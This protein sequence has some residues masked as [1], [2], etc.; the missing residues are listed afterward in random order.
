[1]ND[2]LESGADENLLP[3]SAKVL[4]GS[5]LPPRRTAGE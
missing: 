5:F 4:N 2:L 3:E 1:M